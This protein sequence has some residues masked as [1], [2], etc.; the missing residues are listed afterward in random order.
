MIEWTDE[1]KKQFVVIRIF[2]F[3]LLVA[4]PILFLAVTQFAII[5]IREINGAHDIMLYI[6]LLLAMIQPLVNPLLEKFQISAFKKSPD[7][8]KYQTT[9]IFG[10]FKKQKKK[11]SPIGL[12]TIVTII[13]SVL[14][15]SIYV[16]GLVNFF[17]T[18]D[19]TRMLYFY[20]IGIAWTFVYFPTKERCEKFLEKV[21]S[22][23]IV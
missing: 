8:P 19:L 7:S 22:N 13:K 4:S 10:Y 14:V 12:F 5:P 18:G 1:I 2:G 17:L 23:A 15:E 11:G 6:L 20:P 9:E 16:Y 3:V 21:S